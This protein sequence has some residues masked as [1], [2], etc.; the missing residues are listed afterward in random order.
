MNMDTLVTAVEKWADAKGLFQADGKAQFTKT[1]EETGEIASAICRNDMELLKDSIGEVHY[2]RDYE[3]IKFW[4][5]EAIVEEVSLKEKAY[6][7]DW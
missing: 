7:N 5:G 1:V 6:Q 4:Q 3:F 2:D